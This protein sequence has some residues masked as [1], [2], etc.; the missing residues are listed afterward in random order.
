MQP[1]WDLP[2]GRNALL[3]RF[4]EEDASLLG[5]IL[6]FQPDDARSCPPFPPAEQKKPTFSTAKT[7]GEKI[8][9]RYSRILSLSQCLRRR[10]LYQM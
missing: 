4:S 1:E 5:P 6:P 8:A 9:A 3:Q 7:P 10:A 2:S